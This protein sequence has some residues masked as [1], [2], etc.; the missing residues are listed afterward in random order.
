M[1][2]FLFYGKKKNQ[3]QQQQQ[4]NLKPKP[5]CNCTLQYSS[6]TLNITY[7]DGR[8][9]QSCSYSLHYIQLFFLSRDAKEVSINVKS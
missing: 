3:T 9:P 6:S 4:K 2:I 7:S 8:N 1:G 5:Q